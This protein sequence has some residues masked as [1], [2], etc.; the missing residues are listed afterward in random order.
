M[1]YEPEPD[2]PPPV[3]HY[4][5]PPGYGYPYH[6]PPIPPRPY[7]GMSIAAMVLGIVGACNP[8]GVLALI[9]GMIAK[10]QI[11][12]TGQQGD[13]FAVTGIVL[14]WIGVASVVFWILYLL[15]LFSI[16]IPFVEEVSD[17]A[18]WPSA[19]PTESPSWIASRP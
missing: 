4:H 17:P 6:Q 5:P 9:F 1:S 7:N 18:N 15:A 10:K 19:D 16:W 12:E 8:L 2:A 13:G 3:H 11:R 14:G